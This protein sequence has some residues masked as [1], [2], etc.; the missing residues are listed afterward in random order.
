MRDC[1]N[2]FFFDD[3]TLN[4]CCYKECDDPSLDI[5]ECD[6]LINAAEAAFDEY[7]AECTAD[8]FELCSVLR[9]ENKL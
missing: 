8:Y 1:E 2:C 7:L 3:Y 4:C 9:A 6:D 5:A